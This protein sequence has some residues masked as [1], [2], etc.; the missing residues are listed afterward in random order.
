MTF[1]REQASQYIVAHAHVA[2]SVKHGTLIVHCVCHV[3]CLLHLLSNRR[4]MPLEIPVWRTA[5]TIISG[6][7]DNIML[8][9]DHKSTGGRD[10]SPSKPHQLSEVVTRTCLAV[11]SLCVIC[12]YSCAL[13]KRANRLACPKHIYASI[14]GF[15]QISIVLECMKALHVSI[16][17]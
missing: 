2:F 10:S 14:V 12:V 11:H 7:N 15:C 16:W 17:R 13:N 1:A 5:R 6:K 9:L 8:R 4:G 3:R